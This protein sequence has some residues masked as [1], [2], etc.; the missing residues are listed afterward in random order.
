MHP[1]IGIMIGNDKL[2]FLRNGFI[3][4][5]KSGNTDLIPVWG[6]MNFQQMIEHM[7]DSVAIASGDL[8]YPLMS[9]P[10]RID[11]MKAF[12]VGD[13]PFR[14]NTPNP[15]IGE[16]TLPLRYNDMSESILNLQAQI[17]KFINRFEADSDLLVENPFFGKMNF[18]EWVALLYK[19]A[20]HHLRQFGIEKE[21]PVEQ[22]INPD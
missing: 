13:K 6:K 12:A 10:D 8:S 19:H 9:P 22:I 4:K 2:D 5:L 18:E 11:Q 17:E 16:D 20:W 14:E 1:N 21:K 3:E 7:I 15:I